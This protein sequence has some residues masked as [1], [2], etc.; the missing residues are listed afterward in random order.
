MN[1]QPFKEGTIINS[2]KNIYTVK[3]ILGAGAFGITYL[4]VCSIRI[5]NIPYDFQFA[6]KEHFTHHCFRAPDEITVLSAPSAKKEVE[7]SRKDFLTEARRLQQLCTKSKYIVKVNETFEANGTAYYIMEYLDG[8]TINVSSK[9]Q[10]VEY[11]LMLADAVQ[12]LHDNRVLHM[13]IKPSN[14]VLKM[15]EDTGE[16]YP[17]LIDFGITKHFDSKGKATTAPFAKGVST[18][19][20]PI[21]QYDEVA[22]F[23]PTI[24]IYAMGATLF[25]LL[26]KKNP[27]HAS[28]L[29]YDFKFISNELSSSLC[30]EFIPFITKAMAPNHQDRYQNMQEFVADLKGIRISNKEFQRERTTSANASTTFPNH[31]ETITTERFRTKEAHIPTIPLYRHIHI[32]EGRLLRVNNPYIEGRLRSIIVA[33]DTTTN[34]YGIIDRNQNIIV[35][36]DYLSIGEFSEIPTGRGSNFIFGSRVVAPYYKSSIGGTLRGELEI[37]S[38]GNIVEGHAYYDNE[39]THIDESKTYEIIKKQ[40]FEIGGKK[41]VLIITK[42]TRG[43]FGITDD[44][45]SILAPFIYNSIDMFSEYCMIPGP[46]VPQRFL[47]ASYKIGKEIGF[48]KV[49]ENGSLVDY[50]R[51]DYQTYKHLCSLT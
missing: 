48:F 17:V 47:G 19:Y 44:K 18:G 24:D 31:C 6:I 14:I 40:T 32:F 37:L 20:A 1:A 21:E 8:G 38:G 28:K 26:T 36:F 22:K 7:S 10:A 13:D 50:K 2:G 43:L 9:S 35:P 49:N 15:D 27:P 4:A 51:F 41:I 23:A 39:D 45:G 46:G 5:G 34:L 30:E 3:K 25:F 11:M 12:V 33:Q 29:C 42:D 16:S